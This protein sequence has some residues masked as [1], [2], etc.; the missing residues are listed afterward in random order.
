MGC[1]PVTWTP[2]KLN[3]LWLHKEG[4]WSMVK[5]WWVLLSQVLYKKVLLLRTHWYNGMLCPEDSILQHSFPYSRPRSLCLLFTVFPEPSGSDAVSWFRTEHSTVT[6]SAHWPVLS[7]HSNC[8]P[9]KREALW[10]RKAEST[11][12]YGYKHKYFEG[13]SIL[14]PFG[15]ATVLGSSLGLLEDLQCQ[16]WALPV[17]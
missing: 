9:L 10:V 1:R 5:C 17:E 3:C 13:S 11:L 2:L 16:A 14:C 7:L 12:V 4:W 6:F 8:Y 15:K